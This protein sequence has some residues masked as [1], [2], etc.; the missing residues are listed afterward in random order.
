MF[1]LY[2]LFLPAASQDNSTHKEQATRYVFEDRDGDGKMDREEAPIPDTLVVGEFNMHDSLRRSGALTDE[3]EK[4]AIDAEYIHFFK[5]IV[6]PPCGE[7][8]VPPLYR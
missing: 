5:I 1:V 7:L 2:R 4:T 6:I 8:L 3:E